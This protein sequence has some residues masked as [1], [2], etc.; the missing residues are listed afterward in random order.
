M[1]AWC[2]PAASQTKPALAPSSADSAVKAIVTLSDGK[3]LTAVETKITTDGST[4]TEAVVG[5]QTITLGGAGAT[6]SGEALSLA[7]NGLAVGGTTTVAFSGSMT[8]STTAAT[9]VVATS[10]AAANKQEVFIGMAG[11]AGLAAL[12]Y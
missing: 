5:S 6:V 12:L 7:T 10:S 4:V 2:F 8:T 9:A 1:V 11:M 3:I